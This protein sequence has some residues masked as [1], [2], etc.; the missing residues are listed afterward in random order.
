MH[1]EQLQQYK[2]SPPDIVIPPWE[3]YITSSTNTCMVVSIDDTGA[4]KTYHWNLYQ[5]RHPLKM[6]YRRYKKLPLLLVLCVG[7]ACG[8]G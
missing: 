5:C 4:F 8:R 3:T 2:A 6:K 7:A 1:Q